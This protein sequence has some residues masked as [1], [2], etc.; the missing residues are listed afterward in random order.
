MPIG[1][2]RSWA[3][4]IGPL[5]SRGGVLAA[6]RQLRRQRLMAAKRDA[7]H[8]C[9]GGNDQQPLDKK[10]A[11]G[12][13]RV[14]VSLWA[15]IRRTRRTSRMKCLGIAV[16]VFGAGVLTMKPAVA[17]A[18]SPCEWTS[19]RS[20]CPSP[21]E[22][23]DQC[24]E[25]MIAGDCVLTGGGCRLDDECTYN[26]IF[27]KQDSLGLRPWAAYAHDAKVPDSD[28]FDA[29]VA[30]TGPIR[31]LARDTAVARSIGLNGTPTIV[32]NGWR[33]SSP[34]DLARLDSIVQ[35]VGNPTTK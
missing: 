5:L 26:A 24:A 35:A 7:E 25:I 17:E 2:R 12:T 13:F 27:L 1:R 15:P 22:L 29:C 30:D 8:S 6:R 32:V 28:A 21:Q 14:G 31:R 16:V 20:S 23:L 4:S 33:W 10:T 18:F 9:G 19:C 11:K 3:L 34:P